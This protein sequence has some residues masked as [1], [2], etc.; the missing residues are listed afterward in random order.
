MDPNYPEQR[1]AYMAKDAEAPVLL[2]NQGLQRRL[3]HNSLTTQVSRKH[4]AWQHHCA[5]DAV[6]IVSVQDY[7]KFNHAVHQCNYCTATVPSKDRLYN[8]FA[9]QKMDL[10]AS[11]HTWLKYGCNH[12]ALFLMCRL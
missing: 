3:P 1:L 5:E 9:Y 10:L 6:M 11:A 7:R 8:T 12:H 2:T 4:E